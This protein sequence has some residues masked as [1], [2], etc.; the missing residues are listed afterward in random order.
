MLFLVGIYTFTID[1]NNFGLLSRFIIGC[2][3]PKIAFDAKISLVN[4]DT[5]A[6]HLH[7]VNFLVRLILPSRI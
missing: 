7:H 5:F 4:I 1:K 2:M 6:T 3:I